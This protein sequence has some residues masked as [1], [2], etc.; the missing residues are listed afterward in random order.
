MIL[1]IYIVVHFPVPSFGA[2]FNV[3]WISFLQILAV[4][5]MTSTREKDVVI[6]MNCYLLLDIDLCFLCFLEVC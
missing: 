3:L 2:G 6:T 1:Y 4:S 5:E